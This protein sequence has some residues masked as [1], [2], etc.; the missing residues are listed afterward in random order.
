MILFTYY[1]LSGVP[2]KVGTG[3]AVDSGGQGGGKVK[4]TSLLT[5]LIHGAESFLRS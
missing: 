3:Y 1:H 2:E 4:I 5:Y